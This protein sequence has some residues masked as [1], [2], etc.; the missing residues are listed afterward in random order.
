MISQ[1]QASMKQ[2]N[3]LSLFSKSGNK[4]P[5]PPVTGIYFLKTTSNNCSDCKLWRDCNELMYKTAIWQ[6]VFRFPNSSVLYVQV[7]EV[8]ALQENLCQCPLGGT[9]AQKSLLTEILYVLMVVDQ[10]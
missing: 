10:L 4:F 8:S 9:G 1:A 2:F 6:L 5:Y 7:K 3:L